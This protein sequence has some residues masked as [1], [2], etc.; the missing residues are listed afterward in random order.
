MSD[1]EFPPG[2]GDIAFA[3]GILFLITLY[4]IIFVL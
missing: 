4:V 3:G 1:Y 2:P